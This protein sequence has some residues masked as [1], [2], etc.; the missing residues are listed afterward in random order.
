MH[1][2]WIF[3][4]IWPN[5]YM[6]GIFKVFFIP[7]MKRKLHM[8]DHRSFVFVLFVFLCVFLEKPLQQCRLVGLQDCEEQRQRPCRSCVRS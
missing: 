5:T 3:F 8:Q 4:N 1:I 2:F 7:S 6:E